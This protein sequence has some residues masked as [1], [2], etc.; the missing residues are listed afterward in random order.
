[1]ACTECE[2]LDFGRVKLR[3]RFAPAFLLHVLPDKRVANPVAAR[4]LEA[5]HE[6]IVVF[7][8]A[9]HDLQFNI[10][11][12]IVVRCGIIENDADGFL[13]FFGDVVV[14]AGVVWPAEIRRLFDDEV[15][16]DVTAKRRIA[17]I[18]LGIHGGGVVAV[19]DR[20]P[21]YVV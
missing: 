2:V 16:T 9:R 17:V 19:D 4:I 21:R 6:F 3:N 11:L 18:H 7:D 15:V 14:C 10:A 20:E 1:M 8:L 12:R 13:D 5:D